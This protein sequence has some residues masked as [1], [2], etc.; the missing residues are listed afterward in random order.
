[1]LESI[2]SMWL[3]SYTYV[4]C[5]WIIDERSQGVKC[6]NNFMDNVLSTNY[7]RF[8]RCSLLYSQSCTLVKLTIFSAPYLLMKAAL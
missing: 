4:S 1:M 6:F 2:F 5:T 3:I 7:H 8:S